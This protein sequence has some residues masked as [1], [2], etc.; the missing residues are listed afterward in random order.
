MIL[1][2]IKKQALLLLRNPMELLLLLGLP[3]LLIAI[4]GTALGN[5]M[6]GGEIDL[7]FKLAVIENEAESEQVAQFIAKLESGNLPEEV[8]EELSSTAATVQPVATLTDVLQSEELEELIILEKVSPNELTEVTE[9]DSYAA[10]IEF[11]EGF[12][13]EL[14]SQLFLDE[15]RPPEM[16]V[17]HN[18]GAE[19]AGNIVE[20]IVTAYQ[21]EYT[22]GS[23]L[24][25]NGIDPEQLK[26]LSTDFK[27]E[28][29]SI[30]Q[31]NPV[32]SKAYYTIG[33]VVMNALF[34]APT[35]ASI[36]FREK[37]DN[38]F[39]RMILADISRW[40]Y[41]IS[42]L[43]TGMLFA[44]IQSLVVFTFAYIVFDV[45][46]PDLAAFFIITFFFALAVGGL[47]TLLTAISYRIHSE[48]IISF[49]SGV[50][51]TIFAFLGGSFFPIGE[52]SAFIQRLGDLTPNGAAM[53][54]YLSIIRG[55][56]IMDNTDH[57][58]FICCFALAAIIIGVLTFPK[59]GAAA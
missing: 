19:I 29:S 28:V 37:Q 38:I 11:P 10:I 52:N 58:I 59:R 36:A 33:M 3:I 7:Q 31:H 18:E 43:L 24:G 20:Q 12:T 47:T 50:I 15:G 13:Y 9:D 44:F 4:L 16:T 35:I 45:T 25:R 56:A 41:F 55:E 1:Q 2:M 32:N 53:S 51:V 22:V 5:I 42:V 48:R 30:N 34:M 27:Q 23:F 6:D 26:L 21:E 57:L 54:A 14:L 17:Y 8:I 40:V 39:D 49:F 46:W